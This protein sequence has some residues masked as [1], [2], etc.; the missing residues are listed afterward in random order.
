M[1]LDE[2]P[3]IMGAGWTIREAIDEVLGW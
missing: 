2:E 1:P 3:R